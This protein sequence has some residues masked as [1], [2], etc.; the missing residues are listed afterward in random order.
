MGLLGVSSSPSEQVE[1]TPCY[2]SDPLS[3]SIFLFRIPTEHGSI[4][5]V[6]H[7]ESNADIS[8]DILS[9]YFSLRYSWDTVLEAW[10]S[11]PEGAG[12]SELQK[13]FRTIAQ[14]LRGLRLLRQ[15]PRECLL[16]VLTRIN[17]RDPGW[18]NLQ[19]LYTKYGT[20]VGK[21]EGREFYSCP[22]FETLSQ[23]DPSKLLEMNF[24]FRA[25]SIPK[26][27]QSFN[28]M[29]QEILGSLHLPLLEGDTESDEDPSA[30]QTTTSSQE[31]QT[32]TPFVEESHS[33]SDTEEEDLDSRLSSHRA[34]SL[35]T[36]WITPIHFVDEY[37]VIGSSPVNDDPNG[38]SCV[39]VFAHVE[40]FPQLSS[41]S[42]LYE[43]FHRFVTT[44][45]VDGADKPDFFSPMVWNQ[46][47]G[48]QTGAPGD[49]L[50]SA[51]RE[52]NELQESGDE[53]GSAKQSLPVLPRAVRQILETTQIKEGMCE[54]QLNST[55]E[56]HLVRRFLLTHKLTRISALLYGRVV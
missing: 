25:K 36:P 31:E 13:R 14:P 47:K 28:T 21:I 22:S 8:R 7:N 51:L 56:H 39:T 26:F 50:R 55:S 29:M 32:P 16:L 41:P 49:E 17:K 15:P 1:F 6:C 53:N 4:E 33:G 20:L 42:T 24:G 52:V 38:F 12:D 37:G 35:L 48:Q 43:P 45:D 18:K 27:F 44:E 23:L 2:K 11:A 10:N 40:K 46:R 3:F 19:T 54:E 30:S 9:D 5:Y 34:S